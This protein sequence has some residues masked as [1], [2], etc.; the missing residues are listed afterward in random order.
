V[1]HHDRVTALAIAA[2][3]RRLVS[4][5]RDASSLVWDL[6][7]PPAIARDRGDQAWE[8]L[9]DANASRAYK[10]MAELAAAPERTTR[11]LA[12][13]LRRVRPERSRDLPSPVRLREIRALELL[14]HFGNADARELLTTLANGD[15]T[16]PLTQDAAASL[17]RVV[18]N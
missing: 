16:T 4:A 8:D 1:G 17:R 2:R 18:G 13:R 6:S 10:T 14:E 15:P 9:A 7:F 12:Q 11:R 5:S 3:G